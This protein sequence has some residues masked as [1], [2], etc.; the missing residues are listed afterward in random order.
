MPNV[1]GGKRQ[2]GPGKKIGRPIGSKNAPRIYVVTS[3]EASVQEVVRLKVPASRFERRLGSIR[4]G[5]GTAYLVAPIEAHEARALL[6]YLEEGLE[7]GTI[8][9]RTNWGGKREAR[10]GKRI[11]RPRGSTKLLMAAALAGDVPKSSA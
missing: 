1:W 11:G 10:P 8:L 2:A 4:L 5:M 7:N 3:Q 9:T 6:R